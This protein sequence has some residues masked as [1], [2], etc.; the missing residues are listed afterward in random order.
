MRIYSKFNFFFSVHQRIRN[1]NNEGIEW[2]QKEEELKKNLLNRA[3]GSLT[4]NTDATTTS[5]QRT[6]ANTGASS[7]QTTDV[8][9][10]T[11]KKFEKF[12]KGG[13]K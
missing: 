13:K 4:R 10:L 1:V 7:G 2:L 8:D 12:L 11:R 3:T 9:D 6:S 5:A